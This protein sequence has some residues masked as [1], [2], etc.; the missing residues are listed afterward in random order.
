[1]SRIY[2]VDDD[3]SVLGSLSSTLTGEGWAVETFGDP[4]SFLRKVAAAAPSV[5]I[6]DIFYSDAE[7]CG[8]ELVIKVKDIAPFTQCIIISGESDIQ[9]SIACMKNGAIDFLEKPVS[10]PRLLT[11]V[12]NAVAAHTVKTDASG[13]FQILGNAPSL[14]EMRSRIHKLAVL[15]ESVLICGENGTGKELVAENLHLFSSRSL[16]PLCKINCTALNPNIIESELFGHMAGSFTGAD[17]DKQ[18]CFER[19]N[20]STLFLDEIGDFAPQLQSK[21]LRV[22]QEKRVLPVGAV[23]DVAVDVRLLFAT[24]CDLEAA[25]RSGAFRE[26]LYFR[27]STFVLRIP[28]L[29][30]RLSDI[31]ALAA[32]FLKEFLNENKLPQKMFVQSGLDRLKEYH[33]PGNIRELARIVKNAAFFT[34]GEVI[35]ADNIDFMPPLG[36]PDIWFRTRAMSLS[37]AADYFERELILRRLDQAKNDIG[38]AAEGLGMIKNNLYRKMKQCGI[39]LP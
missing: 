38:L 12:R 11:T 27:I 22:L 15:N 8:D 7:L 30:E 39:S 23:K 36:H 25:V 19:A 2:I 9:K 1:M 31:D 33:Y 13:R 18:G 17:R 26:D 32:H 35:S 29:R 6:I 3:P 28:P 10:L 16:H 24:N 37:Q 5:A 34:E 21:L 20:K 14:A 4:V